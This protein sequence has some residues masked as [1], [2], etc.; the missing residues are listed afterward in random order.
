MVYMYGVCKALRQLK[1]DERAKFIGTSAGC[2]SV[3]S[4]V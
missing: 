3:V 1:V 2:L 4:L